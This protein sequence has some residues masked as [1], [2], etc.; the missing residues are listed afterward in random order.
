[1]ASGQRNPAAGRILDAAVALLGQPASEAALPLLVAATAD[2]PG[3][4]YVGPGG[5][6][7]VRGAPRVVGSSRLARDPRAARELWAITEHATG[8][9]YP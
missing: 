7:E 4:T 6:G 1:M 3:S 9:V 5:L 2:L 8:V